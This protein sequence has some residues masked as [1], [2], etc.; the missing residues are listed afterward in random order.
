VEI[1][2]NNFEQENVAEVST[3]RKDDLKDDSRVSA[4]LYSLLNNLF[5]FCAETFRSC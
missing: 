2:G 5:D 3:F 4:N 1:G